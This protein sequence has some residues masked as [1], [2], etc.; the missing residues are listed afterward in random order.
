MLHIVQTVF[1]GAAEAPQVFLDK[2]AAEVAFVEQ[3]KACWRQSYPAY[4]ERSDVGVDAIASAQAFLETLDLSEKS[5][6]NYWTVSPEGA[7]PGALQELEGVRAWRENAGKSLRRLAQRSAAVRDELTGVL[8]ELTR[9]LAE[10]GEPDGP[11][12]AVQSAGPQGEAEPAPPAAEAAGRK[13]DAEKYATKEWKN[14][15]GTVMNL[16]GG[17][18]NDFPPLPR[19]A[20]RQEVYSDATSLEYWDWVAV[21]IDTYREKAE[22]AGYAVI[23]DPDAPGHYRVRSPE[24]TT[25]GTSFYSVWEAWCQAGMQLP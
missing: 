20:W 24:G 19:S 22:T 1:A 6:I 10:L 4:C 14:F 12:A 7:G 18:R 5:R 15:V 2:A 17:S 21:M 3:V 11:P 23:E 16:S 9:L 8:E 25:G 13:E